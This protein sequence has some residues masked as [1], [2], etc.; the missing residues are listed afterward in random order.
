MSK[1]DGWCP[2][3]GKFVHEIYDKIIDGEYIEYRKWNEDED[4]YELQSTSSDEPMVTFESYCAECNT[5]IIFEET[6][7]QYRV[8]LMN[9]E[10]WQTKFSFEDIYNCMDDEQKA[11]I[12]NMTD[13]ELDDFI[14]ENEHSMEKGFES[15]IMYDWDVIAN[16]IASDL[17]YPD[18]GE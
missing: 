9:T 15:G 18:K 7:N 8:S 2:K 12:D 6:K 14:T 13:K 3:C 10:I 11:I 17:K 4:C 1:P 16:S 5:K